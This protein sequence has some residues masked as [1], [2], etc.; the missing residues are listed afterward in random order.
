[1]KRFLR[2]DVKNSVLQYFP[3]QL[4]V[5]ET[6]E[7]ESVQAELNI[8]ILPCDELLS[9]NLSGTPVQQCDNSF[10]ANDFGFAI[11]AACEEKLSDFDKLRF[12][13]DFYTPPETFKW[14]SATRLDRGK[15]ITCKLRRSELL[16]HR[17]FA[18]SQKLDGVFC[19]YCALF[20]SDEVGRSKIQ[21]GLFVS[22]PFR[23]YTHWSGDVQQHLSRQYHADCTVRAEAFISAM[24]NPKKAIT[25]QIDSAVQRQIENNRRMLVPIIESI[26]FLARCGLPLRG[27]RES[28][29]MKCIPQC[30]EI[31]SNEGNL[32]ALLHFKASSGDNALANHLK[33]ASRNAL[34][35]SHDAQ[36]DIISCIGQIIL[37]TIVKEVKEVGYFSVLAD[38]TT[39]IAG[40]EQLTLVVRYVYD[41]SIKE[42]FIRFMKS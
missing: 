16:L 10:H 17:C 24:R 13:V 37:K 2:T 33:N 30:S 4:K 15:I 28:S 39:D 27:H 9:S 1:M 42:Q 7:G 38:E 21:T 12:L 20:C 6:N 35:I 8:N 14:P 36:S 11:K 3:K 41:K 18:Y 26:L 22:L 31:T 23:R 34:Y 32:R 29:D 19:Q 5:E 40:Q 25:T